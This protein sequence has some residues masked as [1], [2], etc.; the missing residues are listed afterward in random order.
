V[1]DHDRWAGSVAAWVLGA[2]PDGESAELEAHVAGCAECREEADELRRTADALPSVV[3]QV[4]PS[5]EVRQRLMAIVGA[6]AELLAAAGPEADRPRR[7]ARRRRRLWRPVVV[8]PLAAAALAAG[9]LVAV[10]GGGTTTVPAQTVAGTAQL[11][12]HDGS[13]RLVAA[14]LP[15]PPSGRVYQVWLQRG[16]R[17]EATDALFSV[18]RDGR[19]SVDV[20]GSLDGVDKVMVTDEP[21]RGSERPTGKLLLSAEPA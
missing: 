6:E 5:P 1:S 17:V 21:P 13:A 2:L 3:P 11:E 10:L 7:T 19:A 20:P 15:A 4:A 12:I 9:V 18:T 16:D 14:H 8:A